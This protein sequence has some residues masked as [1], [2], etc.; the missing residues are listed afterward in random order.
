MFLMMMNKY[1]DLLLF[2]CLEFLGSTINLVCSLFAY[3]PSTDL[4][5][6]YLLYK[7]ARRIKT[8]QQLR[9]SDRDSKAQEADA[10]K[11]KAFSDE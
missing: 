10:L 1:L 8:E 5:V 2:Y 6:K 4:G 9:V 3:Y 11:E 7:E